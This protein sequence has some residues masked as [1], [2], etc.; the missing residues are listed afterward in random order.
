MIL[1]AVPR[2][3][4]FRRLVPDEQGEWSQP[5]ESRTDHPMSL[6]RMDEGIRDDLW[7]EE[8]HLGLPV[9]LPGGEEGRL[10]RFERS[11]DGSSWTYSLEFRGA[12]ER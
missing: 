2:F 9:L 3:V 7:P 5:L 4:R 6:L 1:H 12:R 11:P 10:E 8:R